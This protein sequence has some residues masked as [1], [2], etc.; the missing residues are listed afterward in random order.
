MIDG[1]RRLRAARAANLPKVPVRVVTGGS[2]AAVAQAFHIHTLR[3]E[4]GQTAQVRSVKRMI[5]L[6][7]SEEPEIGSNAVELRKRIGELTGYRRDR[8]AELI[9]LAEVYDEGVL[10]DVDAKRLRF[11][12][13][14]QIEESFVNQLRTTFPDLLKD[15]GEESVRRTMLDK[16]RRKV[17]T[18][19]RVLMEKLVPVFSRVRTRAEKR[20]LQKLLGEFLHRIE[21]PVEEMVS[22]FEEKYPA[23]RDD[24][25]D[26]AEEVQE[27]AGH[28]RG[29]LESMD[30]ASVRGQYP[31]A[32]RDVVAAL[33]KLRASI[34]GA[35]RRLRG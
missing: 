27:M 17:L 31:K 33:V 24:L 4:W 34:S 3:K 23:P 15:I 1:E 29:V 2:G 30:A 9:R 28:L 32:A 6:I 8:L 13:L 26:L 21:M 19:T 18:S 10:E 12:H 25:L 7:S 11:S 5:D 20:H 35:L 16:A 14:V 22:R